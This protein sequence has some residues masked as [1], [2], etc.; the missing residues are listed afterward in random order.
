MVSKSLVERLKR[1]DVNLHS[2][3]MHTKT[4]PRIPG[5][6][7]LVCALS[8]DAELLSDCTVVARSFHAR[9]VGRGRKDPKQTNKTQTKVHQSVWLVRP[10]HPH[11][12]TFTRACLLGTRGTPDPRAR[13]SSHKRRTEEQALARLVLLSQASKPSLSCLNVSEVQVLVRI[14]GTNEPN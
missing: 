10:Q 3:D 5:A 8:I 7:K 4:T 6:T 12:P 1:T 9:S 2:G 11:H 13:P 14:L